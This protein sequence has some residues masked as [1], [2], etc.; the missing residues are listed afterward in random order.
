MEQKYIAS[1]DFGTSEVKISLIGMDGTVQGMASADYPLLTPHAGWAEQDPAVYWDAACLATKKALNQTEVTSAQV[2]GVVFCTQW[3]GIIPLDGNNHVLHNNMI[4]LDGRAGEQAKR[5]N[6]LMGGEYFCDKDYWPKLLWLKEERPDVYSK[7][8]SILEVNSYLKFRATGLKRVDLTNHFTRSFDPGMQK[9][10]DDILSAAQIDP[11]LFPPICMPYDRVGF[12]LKQP[13]QEIGLLAGTPVFGGCGDIPAIAI[14]AG[15]TGEWMSHIYMGSSGWLGV[16]VPQGTEHFCE[17]YSAFESEKDLQL[18]AVQSVGTAFNWAIEQ[19]YHAEKEQM[20]GGIVKYVDKETADIPAGSLNLVATSWLHGERPPL[21]EKAK[22][23]FL[24]ATS[25]HDR[26]H[27]INALM[28]GICYMLRWKVDSFL[29]QSKQTLTSIRV[30]GGAA[31]S[32]HWMQMLADVL[33]ITVEIPANV[34][35]T[36]AIGTAY[37]AFIGLGMCGDFKEA[38][39]R[40]NAERIFIPRPENRAIYNKLY[41]VYQDIYPSLENI[42]GRLND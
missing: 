20:H 25:L 16:C 42:F 36:G 7:T 29:K 15:R 22:V 39:R 5:L 23:V 41:D 9:F 30:V 8:E 37:C 28:E 6:E 24:N 21:S 4:W 32:D 2:V 11:G 31:N 12:F 13:S 18:N 3:K 27:F 26:R 33:G 10:Y 17:L 40:I 35:H 38:S 19:F 14:G 1:Y 34:Q